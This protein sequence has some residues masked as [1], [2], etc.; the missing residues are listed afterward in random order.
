MTSIPSPG[1]NS[2]RPPT[3]DPFACSARLIELCLAGDQA[4]WD[5][6]IQQCEHLIF[7][8]AR[9]LCGN[10]EDASDI[11]SHV[12]LRLFHSLHTYREGRSFRSWLLRIVHNIYI[13]VYVRNSEHGHLSLDASPVKGHS[14]YANWLVDTTGSPETAFLEQETVQRMVEGL[15]HLPRHQRQALLLFVQGRSYKE[16]AIVTGLS[17]GTVKSRI[18]RARSTLSAHLEAEE[19]LGHRKSRSL[20]PRRRKGAAA[21]HLNAVGEEG[22]GQRADVI[23]LPGRNL[24]P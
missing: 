9:S 4:A 17:M 7:S 20:H 21:A 18:S 15:C 6:L 2:V 24:T 1:Q 12:F 22:D 13:D 19:A 16:I 10:A 5:R 11:T 3:S 23:T 8:Y 14:A